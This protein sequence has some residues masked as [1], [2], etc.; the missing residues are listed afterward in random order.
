MSAPVVWAVVLV[1]LPLGVAGAFWSTCGAVT[2]TTSSRC[3]NLRAG[4]LHRCQHHGGAVAV[5]NDLYGLIAVLVAVVGF[6]I[7]RAMYPGPVLD[8]LLTHP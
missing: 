7:W 3:R 6:L 1:V 2:R 4:P 5:R 8:H